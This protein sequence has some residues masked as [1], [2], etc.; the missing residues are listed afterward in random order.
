[1]GLANRRL[2]RSLELYPSLWLYRMYTP[3]LAPPLYSS[4][5]D[6]QGRSELVKLRIA[7]VW[8]TR[9]LTVTGAC[10]VCG[11]P[12]PLAARH[13]SSYSYFLIYHFYITCGSVRT[14]LAPALINWT[15][16][17]PDSWISME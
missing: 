13:D 11:E 7:D 1:M 2:T 17:L 16:W 15:Q 4:L 6:F 9:L 12:L 3:R 10:D 8:L 5:P 14:T